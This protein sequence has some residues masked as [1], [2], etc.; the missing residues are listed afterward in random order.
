M[1]D[2]PGSTRFQALFESALKAYEK[3]TGVTLAEHP[4]SL[5]LQNCQDVQ[6][7]TN[8]LQDQARLFDDF[9]ANDRIMKSIENTVS[10]LN[11]LSAPVALGGSVGLVCQRH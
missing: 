3:N 7:I 4:L 10:I 1:S 6:S 9:R 5:Q 11:A 8:L 2:Q